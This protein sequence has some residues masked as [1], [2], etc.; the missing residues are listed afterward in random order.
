MAF[1]SQGFL[2][3]RLT[4]SVL[5]YLLQV[6]Y[7]GLLLHCTCD[8]FLDSVQ[9]TKILR[10]ANGF[11]SHRDSVPTRDF[12]GQ[13]QQFDFRRSRPW[14]KQLGVKLHRFGDEHFATS[15]IFAQA[16]ALHCS[17]YHVA[18][19]IYNYYVQ[20]LG[21]LSN[22]YQIQHWRHSFWIW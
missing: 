7:P 21:D 5:F 19:N 13:W 4:M 6:S 20:T 12:C 17:K 1:C 22:L 3:V 11:G 16:S 10:M 18:I 15:P 2:G 9:C 14:W 8:Y